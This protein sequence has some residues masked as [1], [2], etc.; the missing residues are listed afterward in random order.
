MLVTTKRG[1]ADKFRVNVQYQRG[2]SQAFRLPEFLNGY[3]YANAVNE[4]LAN[5]GLPARFSQF[6]LNDYQSGSN[7]S[8]SPDVNWKKE[9]LRDF[10]AKNDFSVS[11][12]G[13]SKI[14]RYFAM[15]SYQ[16]DEGLF[17]PVNDNEGYSTQLGYDKFNFR[18]NL[19]IDLSKSTLLQLNLGGR[20][21]YSNQPNAGANSVFH[22]IFATPSGEFPVKTFNGN[23]GGTAELNNNP[24]AMVSKTGYYNEIIRGLLGNIRVVQKLDFIIKGLSAEASVNYDNSVTYREGKSKSYKYEKVNSLR[25]ATGAI[26]DTVSVSYGTESGLN[27][28]SDIDYQFRN[29]GLW[30][31]MNYTAKLFG[32]K[33]NAALLYNQSKVIYFGQY[34]TFIRQSLGLLA[35]YNIANKYIFSASLTNGGSNILPKDS[36]FAYFPAISG[37]WVISKED[38]MINLSGINYLKLRASWG[39]TGSD[40]IPQNISEQNFISGR[41]YY[42]KDASTS[43][44]GFYEGRLAYTSITGE[45]GYKTNVGLDLTMFKHL[46]ISADIFYNKQKNIPV[47]A[48]GTTS[49]IVGANAPFSNSGIVENKGFELSVCWSQNTGTGLNYYLEGMVSFAQNKIVEMDE[50]YRPYPYLYRTG[51]P[52][53]QYYGLQ[54]EGFFKD[55]AEI[56]SSPVQQF[57]EV[58]PGSVKYKDQNADNLIDGNDVVAIGYTSLPEIS[59]SMSMGLDYKGLGVDVMFQGVSN[60]TVYMNTVGVF[61]PLRGTNSLSTFSEDRWT[62]ATAETAS[63]P[64]Y[65]M[66]TNLNDYQSNSIWLKNGAFLKLR[67]AQ[68]FYTLPDNFTQ[69]FKL[70]KVRFFLR[71]MNLLSFDGIK[72]LDPETINSNYPT[73]RT[74]HLGVN[75]NF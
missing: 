68:V 48:D 72:I 37:A 28:F 52:I 54:A 32:N 58:R 7:P 64:K 26:I 18:T 45:K 34:N 31:K 20:I 3:E 66:E 61:W 46:D 53:G 55:E 44:S 10:G 23:W 16:N 41:N 74:F 24:V 8:F 4:A 38:F 57:S 42:F 15:G 60:N 9:T 62:P 43:Y 25:D 40:K 12:T 69:K 56:A 50:Q 6:D 63:L 27:Y 33:L 65:S 29:S 36:R 73:L 21:S 22:E 35:D 2:I 11:F 1:D 5:D 19:D 13:G 71:G 70:S 75:L 47:T 51:K 14:A 39:I 49:E 67:Q 17:K 59:F 30:G